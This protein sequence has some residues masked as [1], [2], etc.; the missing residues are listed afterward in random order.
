[1]VILYFILMRL[2]GTNLENI[3]TVEVEEVSV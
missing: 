1:M 2:N 3:N